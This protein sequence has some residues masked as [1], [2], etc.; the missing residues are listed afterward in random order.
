MDDIALNHK[1]Y[2]NGG[3]L[4]GL[5]EM[6]K[7]LTYM[8]VRHSMRLFVEVR[9]GIAL[10]QSALKGRGFSRADGPLGAGL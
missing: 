2:G 9:I 6:Q 4:I 7:N 8:V 3:Q 5:W 10:L 1:R